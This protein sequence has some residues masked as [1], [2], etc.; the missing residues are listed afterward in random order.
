MQNDFDEGFLGFLSDCTQAGA[1]GT[2]LLRPRP[3]LWRVTGPSECS[4]L[5]WPFW[6][7]LSRKN[8]REQRFPLGWGPQTDRWYEPFL[9]LHSPAHVLNA[10]ACPQLERQGGEGGRVR[11]VSPSEERLRC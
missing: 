11:I 5:S 9:G 1:L 7:L 4:S 2:A 8:Y 3:T 6:A 10:L